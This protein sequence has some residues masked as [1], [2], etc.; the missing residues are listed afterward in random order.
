MKKLLVISRQVFF[1]NST[2]YFCI[3]KSKSISG[4]NDFAEKMKLLNLKDNKRSI[5]K[6]DLTESELAMY[7]K[8]MGNNSLPMLVICMNSKVPARKN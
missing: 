4:H 6:K 7:L 1:K 2:S 8:C 5:G 3:K